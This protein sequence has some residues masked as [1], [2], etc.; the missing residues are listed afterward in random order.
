MWIDDVRSDWKREEDRRKP[1]T[2]SPERLKIDFT[3]RESFSLNIRRR[4]K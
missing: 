2:I 4:T 1:L 3:L